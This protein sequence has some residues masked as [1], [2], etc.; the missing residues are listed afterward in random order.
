MGVGCPPDRAS[1][2]D[3]EVLPTR[4]SESRCASAGN[5]GG[6]ACG[7]GD[8]SPI[9][10]PS[11]ALCARGRRRNRLPDPHSNPNPHLGQVVLAGAEESR[12]A[13]D[14]VHTAA[15]GVAA[16]ATRVPLVGHGGDPLRGHE[17]SKA[18]RGT[19][20][21][22]ETRIGRQG[23]GWWWWQRWWWWWS[24]RRWGLLCSSSECVAGVK[25]NPLQR[26]RACWLR[27]NQ[28]D[29]RRDAARCAGRRLGPRGHRGCPQR[30][31]PSGTCT[32]VEEVH[33]GR[34]KER[35]EGSPLEPPRPQH[36][37]GSAFGSAFGSIFKTAAVLGPSGPRTHLLGPQHEGD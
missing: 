35:E 37:L 33:L 3:H 26:W 13:H 14:A 19:E 6:H 22:G 10:Q 18:A 25:T 28:E 24:W 9:S 29:R 31:A 4:P 2:L 1:N 16:P 21:R 27:G 34:G 23:D 12:G 32:R 5:F 30:R 20:S 8:A 15:V 11:G 7:R 17:R 36:H